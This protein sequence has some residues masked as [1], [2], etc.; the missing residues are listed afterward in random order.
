MASTSPTARCPAWSSTGA[1]APFHTPMTTP[2]GHPKPCCSPTPTGSKVRGRSSA[3]GRTLTIDGKPREI[4]GVL[5]RGFQFLDR[6][7]AALFVPIQWDRSKT[8]L[9]NFSYSALA[10]LKPGV[11]MQQASADMARLLPISLRSF[12]APRG[13]S[14]S[15]FEKAAFQP[16]L[17]PLKQDVSVTWATCC[18]CSWAPSSWSCW[19]PA[20][21]SQT[22]YWCASKAAARNCHPLRAWCGLETHRCG[23]PDGERRPRSLWA[24]SSALGCVYGALRILVALAPTGLPRLHE[25]GINLPVLLFTLGLALLM[26]R[27]HR[28]HSLSSSMPAKTPPAG[29][30][31]ADAR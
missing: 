15:L 24:H 30:V 20:P 7:D 13:F 17:R 31:K 9:G 14:V 6:K 29:C 26:Q 2:R 12:P 16:K 22:C 28:P 5:P 21:T 3:I 27:A 4:I 1:R 10:R 23:P 18:G 25:I 8:K 11:T 19:W